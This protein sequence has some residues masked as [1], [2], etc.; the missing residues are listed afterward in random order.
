MWCYTCYLSGQSN[1]LSSS[2]LFCLFYIRWEPSV[3]WWCIRFLALNLTPLNLF[4]TDRLQVMKIQCQL[5]KNGDC[6]NKP[7]YIVGMNL[8]FVFCYWVNRAL[9]ACFLLTSGPKATPWTEILKFSFLTTH[10]MPNYSGCAFTVQ[11]NKIKKKDKTWVLIGLGKEEYNRF[12]WLVNL[13]LYDA[14]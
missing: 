6:M 9:L 3:V 4:C 2:G 13:I 1:I 14:Q 5:T 10:Q 8:V 7:W 11:L 12:W